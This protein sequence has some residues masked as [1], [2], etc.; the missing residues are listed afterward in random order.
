[1]ACWHARPEVLVLARALSGSNPIRVGEGL[2]GRALQARNPIRFTAEP[3][4][5]RGALSEAYREA[6]D[7]YP[8][9]S[10]IAVPLIARGEIVGLVDL[11]RMGD[12]AP[13]TEADERF[14]QDFGGRVALVLANATLLDRV[15][16]ELAARER[17]EAALHVYAD[18]V[19]ATQVGLV[20]LRL[21][22]WEVLIA[23][24]PALLALGV[25]TPD[26][27][28][29]SAFPPTVLD[30]A[31][32]ATVGTPA[33]VQGELALPGGAHAAHVVGL[34]GNA[35]G[36]ALYDLTERRAHEEERLA[37]TS[38][39]LHT[40]KLESLG[41]LAGGIAHDFNNLLV[42]VLG[43]ATLALSMVPAESPASEVLG[44]IESTANRASHLTRQLLAYS[45]KGRFVVEPIDLNALVREMSEL[46]QVSVS[47]RAVVRLDLQ[48]RSPVVEADVAQ[49]QQVVLNLITNASDAI[50]DRPGTITIATGTVDADRGY[51]DAAS[52][53][54]ILPEGRY[55]WLEVS[56]TGDG[57]SKEVIARV[58]EPFFTTKANGRGL[59]LSAVQ[60]IVRSHGGALRIYSEP[61]KGTSMKVILPA[62]E[63]APQVAV[64]RPREAAPT[65]RYGVLVVDD[66]PV[67]REVGCLALSI[68]GF[69]VGEA[70]DG[71]EAIAAF[72][73]EPG[74]WDVVLLDM[75]MPGLGG[76]ETF[77]ELRRLAPDVRVVL[78]SG[79]TSRTPRAGWPG[80]AWR[81]SSRSPGP[82]SSYARRSRRR[83]PGS[84]RS[85]GVRGSALADGR[86]RLPPGRV[87][88][89]HAD[90]VADD[91]LGLALLQ[92]RVEATQ[93]LAPVHAGEVTAMA[94]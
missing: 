24:R 73:R 94:P 3:S 54:R 59:G 48:E 49:I 45:G 22:P 13:F 11:Y 47:R 26:A 56:D 18:L 17:A 84:A 34:P 20:A 32:R 61:G 53:D 19:E 69:D 5:F 88:P 15:Q 52:V 74:R 87:H 63:V 21:E 12:G 36:V 82:S 75:T 14:A 68:A 83:R 80:R 66:E 38:R 90:G 79:Y 40:Q 46:L 65:R 50:G 55:A 62:C 44:R 42:G 58:F 28:G 51:L 93:R 70:A 43:N 4:V 85:G 10:L 64:E 78:S 29:P 27:L 31:R 91:D 86:G 1:V 92:G 76:A 23:N 77:A 8:L 30:A 41:V 25:A 39:L 16:R 2:R 35:A 33:V 60:G 81:A 7:R 67:V 37:L 71:A 89:E 72:L 57:M 6:F 9:R